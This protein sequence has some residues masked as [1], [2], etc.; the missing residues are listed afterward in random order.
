M[1]MA[2]SNLTSAE[3]DASS[4]SP[5]TRGRREGQPHRRPRAPSQTLSG[6]LRALVERDL[7]I[8]KA[9]AALDWQAMADSALDTPT[10]CSAGSDFHQ[11]KEC[12]MR[13]PV[14]LQCPRPRRRHDRLQK[15]DGIT[16]FQK[17]EHVFQKQDA[18]FGLSFINQYQ[19]I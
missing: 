19:V 11:E 7:A 12:A 13:P 17:H 18:S 9:G 3:Q 15:N 2:T 10:P 1:A 16:F 8:S 6:M 4:R 5:R 14:H